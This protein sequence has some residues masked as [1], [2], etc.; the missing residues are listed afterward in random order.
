MQVQQED[1]YVARDSKRT[2]RQQRLEDG[3]VEEE[4]DDD[5]EDALYGDRAVENED[6][7]LFDVS[8]PLKPL[9]Q[10]QKGQQQ[11]Q[12]QQIQQI[13]TPK[14]QKSQ[15]FQPWQQ[16]PHPSRPTTTNTSAPL[17]APALGQQQLFPACLFVTTRLPNLQEAS[18]ITNPLWAVENVMQTHELQCL[19]MTHLFQDESFR[20]L[21][22]GTQTLQFAGAVSRLETEL[23][24]MM[25][26]Y[27]RGL[28]EAQTECDKQLSQV[29][30]NKIRVQHYTTWLQFLS[31]SFLGPQRNN[32]NNTFLMYE[33]KDSLL[34]SSQSSGGSSNYEEKLQAET[35]QNEKHRRHLLPQLKE[36]GSATEVREQ[37]V[38]L[39]EKLS[40]HSSQVLQNTETLLHDFARY[41]REKYDIFSQV[42]KETDA[43][44]EKK[45][46]KIWFSMTP[47]MDLACQKLQ[48]INK[49][50]NEVEEKTRRVY[51]DWLELGRKNIGE[52]EKVVRA[53][54]TCASIYEKNI[55]SVW[56]TITDIY[57]FLSLHSSSLVWASAQ[58]KS[59]FDAQLEEFGQL[60][61]AIAKQNPCL[62]EQ[63]AEWRKSLYEQTNLPLTGTR[64]VG[65]QHSSAYLQQR[66]KEQQQ[67]Q[68]QPWAGFRQ[69]L[70]RIQDWFTHALEQHDKTSKNRSENSPLPKSLSCGAK[71]VLFPEDTLNKIDGLITEHMAELQS[72]YDTLNKNILYTQEILAEIQINSK[73]QEATKERLTKTN[74]VFQSLIR[75]L[76]QHQ[77]EFYQFLLPWKTQL[78]KQQKQERQQE[79]RE[80]AECVPC[81]IRKEGCP[82]DQMIQNCSQWKVYMEQVRKQ[83]EILKEDLQRD[84][85]KITQDIDILKQERQQTWAEYTESKKTFEK[86]WRAEMHNALGQI[87]QQLGILLDQQ[88]GW[89]EARITESVPSQAVRMTLAT[90]EDI[91]QCFDH[92]LSKEDGV[93]NRFLETFER[94][95]Y[96]LTNFFSSACHMFE[97]QESMGQFRVFSLRA[98]INNA[99]LQRLKQSSLMFSSRKP[100]PASSPFSD[101][102]NEQRGDWA[103]SS[104][105][106][107]RQTWYSKA[108]EELLA[109]TSF[110]Q[111]DLIFQEDVEQV[112]K[113]MD[114][115]PLQF[116]WLSDEDDGNGNTNQPNWNNAMRISKTEKGA[117]T[118][119]REEIQ[120]EHLDTNKKA[121]LKHRS[122]PPTRK[123]QRQP[124][125]QP[126]FLLSSVPA[127]L[128]PESNVTSSLPAVESNPAKSPSETLDD[129]K[130]SEKNR[131]QQQSLPLPSARQESTTNPETGIDQEKDLLTHS[132]PFAIL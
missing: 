71:H 102:Q 64:F 6:E 73:R 30:R 106:N 99:R 79:E 11:Q 72:L 28:Q 116:E 20:D 53:S 50:K 42:F 12:Q 2:S 22:V 67:Q 55:T 61:A 19:E 35:T 105:Q 56:Q 7:E 48:K 118:E 128:V 57:S 122:A 91:R 25:K 10:G 54:Q 83:F 103:V 65:R 86:A 114:D 109:P 17:A 104:P 110:F 112:E 18:P 107:T 66:Q 4:D 125:K 9:R 108:W 100:Q 59:E 46:Q 68:Q 117:S 97:G 130:A 87:G 90:I 89:W 76:A 101:M 121:A 120:Q 34:C 111:P 77:P 33:D 96:A 115:N 69:N 31:S 84:L 81:Q 132:L 21:Q 95:A 49:V 93:L 94:A 75:L 32:S 60:I 23:R 88:T 24:R 52:A 98:S 126:S 82:L 78:G 37:I 63:A 14:P 1:A 36:F 127:P 43:A 40:R 29:R 124:A 27:E 80:K 26:H 113:L 45:K 123:R 58:T 44:L 119:K 47:Q 70:S 51:K 13:Q 39:A 92:L 131:Q 41:E 38:Q 74:L 85:E 62:H 16:A 15:P 5:D 129:K 3:G 8:L